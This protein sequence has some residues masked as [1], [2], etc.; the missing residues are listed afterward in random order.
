MDVHGLLQAE[1]T[2]G[3]RSSDVFR[4]FGDDTKRFGELL[5]TNPSAACALMD[6]LKTKY[7]L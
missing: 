2:A 1:V 5:T 7:N 3:K 4:E 6:E